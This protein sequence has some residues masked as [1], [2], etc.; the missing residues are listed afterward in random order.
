MK[1]A[2][3]LVAL[4]AGCAQ[5]PVLQPGP[6]V[7]VPVAVP[8]LHAPLV[9]PEFPLQSLPLNAGAAQLF[10]ACLQT[11]SLRQ[12]YELECE[13]IVTACQ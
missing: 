1:R 11:D 9:K 13:A 3:M 5:T 4:L 8:C 7:D 2:L 12:A 6:E 10:Q